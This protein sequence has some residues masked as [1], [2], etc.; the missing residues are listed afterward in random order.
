VGYSRNNLL[1]VEVITNDIQNHFDAFRD[2]LLKTG[3]VAEVAK[4]SAP[5]TETR[6]EEGNFDWDGRD[7]TGNTQNFYDIGVSKT[8]G[9]TVGWQFVAGRDYLTGPEGA[10]AQSFV[11]NESAIKLFGFKNPFN[12]TIRWYGYNFHII[13]VVKDM[14]MQSPFSPTVP[15]IFFM[16]PWPISVINV[17][18]NPGTSTAAAVDKIKAVF[19]QYNPAQPFDCKFAD[20]EYARKFAAEERVG[21]LAGF[22]AVLAI[23]ISCL[24]LYGMASFMAERRIKEISM[25]K[26]LG[27]SVLNLW[28]LLSKDFVALVII[29]LLIATPVAYLFMYNWLQHYEYHTGMAW[30][31]FAGTGAAA[32]LITLLTVSWQSIK[33]ALANPV[34]ALKAE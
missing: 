15:T 12:K 16:A 25:R 5:V 32:L 24:G 22:F 8:Y 10:D 26:V 7:K 4:S 6:N 34:K 18:L 27:A 13:G 21:K 29:S 28:G 11:V 2:D 3:V 23:F 1:S 14:V 33:V 31:V 17:R 20:D 30:W 19:K 9:K